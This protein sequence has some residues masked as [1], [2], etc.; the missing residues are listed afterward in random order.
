MHEC[1]HV[2]VSMDGC[3]S[4]VNVCVCACGFTYVCAC[5][6]VMCVCVCVCSCVRVCV[7]VCVCVLM[8][9]FVSKPDLRTCGAGMH[10]DLYCVTTLM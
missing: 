6:C 1:T 8:C 5:V 2:H 3:L 10:Q 4:V 7:C 9:V